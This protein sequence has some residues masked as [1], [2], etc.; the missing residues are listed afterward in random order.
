VNAALE[1]DPGLINR[2]PYDQGWMFAIELT[3]PAETAQLMTE[4]QYQE[5]LKSPEASGHH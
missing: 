3:T 5:F 4:A 2:S 1:A